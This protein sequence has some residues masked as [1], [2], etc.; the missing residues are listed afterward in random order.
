M[1]ARHVLSIAALPF[2]VTVLVPW[3]I[4]RQEGASFRVG[5]TP[6]AIAIQVVGIGVLLIGLTLFVASLRQFIV[7]G[8]GTLA[9]WDP[10]K[11][12]VVE[13]PYRYVRNPMISGVL[14]I[15]C[16]EAMVLLSPA[17]AV[18]ALIFLLANV[19]YI[20]ISE[21]PGLRQRFGSSYDEYCANVGR[22]I[23]RITPWKSG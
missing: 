11:H 8:R 3:W 14:F 1:L 4:A 7:R 16:S 9:P 2:T 6:I 10:P 17:H 20:P 5:E 21:E 23:P 22:F 12:L 15:V 18:W 19:T 13:G